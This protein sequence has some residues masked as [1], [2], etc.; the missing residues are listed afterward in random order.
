[1]I[2]TNTD[3]TPGYK[4]SYAKREDTSETD[5]ANRT[6]LGGSFSFALTGAIHE[7]EI[8]GSITV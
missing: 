2:V 5:R 7:V 1:M 3:G 6:Y 8:T 4:V